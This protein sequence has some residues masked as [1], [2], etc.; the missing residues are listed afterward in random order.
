[1]PEEAARATS[2]WATT[3][4]GA[5]PSGSCPTL[6]AATSRSARAHEE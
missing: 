4:P 3:P 2:S 1:M 6:R 5:R